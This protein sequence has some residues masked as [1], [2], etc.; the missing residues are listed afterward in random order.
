MPSSNFVA[1][2]SSLLAVAALAGMLTACSA[3]PLPTF[4]APT[5]A[6]EQSLSDACSVSGVDVQQLMNSTEQQLQLG[7]ADAAAKFASGE[8]FS[9]QSLTGPLEAALTDLE[10]QVTNSELL[11]SIGE[12][13]QALSGFQ[14]ISQPENALGVPGYL[15]DLGTQ[16][17]E[18]TQAGERLQA[19]CNAG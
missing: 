19:L 13:R 6:P 10:S 7:I 4:T 9:L 3:E 15:A 16:L 1:R 18:L 14:D 8:E 11:A 2:A 12:V 5:M 17:N